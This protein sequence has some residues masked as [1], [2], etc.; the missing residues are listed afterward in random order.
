MIDQKVVYEWLPPFCDVCNMVGHDCKKK[1]GVPG[2]KGPIKK[3]WVPK[4]VESTT[5][6]KQ[7]EP[8][9][10]SGPVSQPIQPNPAP[11]V[12]V[13]QVHSVTITPQQSPQTVHSDDDGGWKLVTSS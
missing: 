10:Q 2:K 5:V 3:V 1:K 4:Q 7:A 12:P 13:E 9:T 11:V 8:T 6:E